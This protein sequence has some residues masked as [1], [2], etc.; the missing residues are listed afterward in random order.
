MG[1]LQVKTRARASAQGKQRVLFASHPDDHEASFDVISDEIL[2]R[3]N[4]AIYYAPKDD[5]SD[6]EIAQMQ[7]VVLP[8]TKSFL[9]NACNARL[10]V[11]PLATS[12]HIPVLPILMD[13]GISEDFNRI[14][15]TIQYLDPAEKD[16]TAL[17]YG[18]KLTRFLDSVLIGDEMAEKIRA[19]FD[20]YIFLSYR[21]K[22]RAY[23]QEL[24]HLI[25]KNRFCKD[26]AI[27]YDEYLVPG[28]NF[29]ESIAE[30]L[31]KSRLFVLAVTPNLVNEEN[32]VMTT[33]YP[34]A[35]AAKKPILP[36]ELVET[37]A[38]LLK[39]KYESIPDKVDARD[40]VSLS[41]A[42]LESIKRLAITKND[43]PEH[44]F[45]IGLAYL[46][47]VDVEVDRK[48]GRALIT[49][50]A[51]Q[52]VVEAM[53]KLVEIY[54]T[55]LGC[56]PNHS[57]V[58]LWQERK[59]K[60]SKERYTASPSK[61]NAE[62]VFRAILQLGDIH[63][64]SYTTDKAETQY[65]R[66]IAFGRGAHVTEEER[67]R[68]AARAFFRLGDMYKFLSPAESEAYYMQGTKPLISI[69]AVKK[70]IVTRRLLAI[71]SFKQ[72]ELLSSM[73]RSEEACRHYEWAAKKFEELAKE[74]GD[75]KDKERLAIT[76]K[77]L[78]ASLKNEEA[79]KAL[80]T[81]LAAYREIFQD[82]GTDIA[83]RELARC[84]FSFVR[85]NATRDREK[86]MYYYDQIK[87]L[88]PEPHP[89]SPICISFGFDSKGRLQLPE[90]ENPKVILFDTET[91]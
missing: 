34:M 64:E 58:L 70:S 73:R 12:L 27:W 75:I 20:A 25:H 76:W 74:T 45:F 60:A 22:D 17:P 82:T 49:R 8:I 41:Q 5:I 2:K 46:G 54:R 30:A 33:E 59:I 37:D 26:I 19:A 78:G 31:E 48:R 57:A 53:S 10:A 55:G 61:E 47:G 9:H 89:D 43:T 67:R 14:C 71:G 50:A 13:T 32:Y 6:D 72:G 51:E 7:L 62:T 44:T 24:M 77:T 1:I 36:A 56:R 18:E 11:L 84:Y 21:K 28:E 69:A 23:A 40:R 38:S 81:A 16:P 90:D 88:Y 66:A 87:L 39:E 79:D 86:A 29:N 83:R 42:L 65:K 63:S 80:T 4:C 68:F 15:G 3:H 91:N 52:G 85:G 35:R